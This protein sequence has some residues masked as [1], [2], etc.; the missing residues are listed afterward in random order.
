VFLPGRSACGRTNHRIKG[1]LGRA[2]QST[3]VRGLF[4]HPPQ[5]AAT[6]AQHGL[7]KGR[8]VVERHATDDRLRLL[9]EA[10]TS[11]EGLDAALAATLRELTSLRGEVEIVTPGSLPNDG[12]V[13]DDQR[14]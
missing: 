12:K 14:E 10:A 5:V 3:K 2:D 8:L 4:V 13:I 7:T 11:T 1:W 6:L 9:V